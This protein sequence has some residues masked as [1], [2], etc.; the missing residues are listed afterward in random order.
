MTGAA[1]RGAA[2]V[3]LAALLAAGGYVMLADFVNLRRAE[4]LDRPVT[5]DHLGLPQPWGG[6]GWRRLARVAGDAAVLA[7]DTARRALLEAAERYPLDAVQWL[8][9]ARIHARAGNAAAVDAALLRANAVQPFQRRALWAAAQVAL[10]TGNAE[11]AERQLRRWLRLYPRDTGQ[12]LF[13]GR[14]WIDSPGALIDRMLP[15]GREFLAEAMEVAR[16]QSDPALAEAVW[17]RLDPAPEMDDPLFLN[18]AELL[19]A[20]GQVERAAELWAGRDATYTVGGVANGSF[21]RPPGEALGLNWRTGRVPAGVRVERDTE[22]ASSPPASLRVEFNG[23]ENIRLGVPWIRIPVQPGQ[24]YRL[25]GTWRADGLTTRSLPYLDLRAEGGGLRERLEVPGGDFD[26]RP[27]S[28]EFQAPADAQLI[29]L[30]LRRNRTDAFDRNIAGT[31]WLDDVELELV[32]VGAAAV[33]GLRFT[34]YGENPGAETDV[35]AVSDRDLSAPEA[36]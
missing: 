12:A 8:D 11:L 25:S 29:R 10:Q 14:R 9:L 21:S 19:L 23:K 5:P 1:R 4:A 7:P 30:Q 33:D 13:I 35:G 31:L 18:F 3:L 6:Y 28:I 26:W 32:P 20:T 24:H 2:G 16:R 17:Q 36:P 15:E 27:W 22:Q 34:V